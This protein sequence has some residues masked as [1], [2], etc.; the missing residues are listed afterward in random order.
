MAAADRA[1]GGRPRGGGP[2]RGAC[3]RGRGT[4]RRAAARAPRRARPAPCAPP[5]GGLVVTRRCAPVRGRSARGAGDGPPREKSGAEKKTCGPA[6]RGAR[7]AGRGARGAG[8]GA[9]GAGRGARGR[10]ARQFDEGPGRSV[11]AAHLRHPGAV[12]ARP[13]AASAATL[14][15]A[16]CA[17]GAGP[18]PPSRTKWTRLVHPSVLIGQ[19]FARQG[20]GRGDK[21][22]GQG[23]PRRQCTRGRRS[24]NAAGA[25]GARAG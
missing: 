20:H 17:C 1:A 23:R 24:V 9:R 16:W 4:W 18:P 2:G 7:G 19:D 13:A 11:V 22:R 15:P 5:R 21:P 14:S 10:D 12:T 3:T 25:A 8:R 6:G